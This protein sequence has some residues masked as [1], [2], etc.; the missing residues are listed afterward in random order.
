MRV[1]RLHV[2]VGRGSRALDRV[3]H[4]LL[5]VLANRLH[6]RVVQQRATA[7]HPLEQQ[8]RVALLPLLDLF[9]RTVGGVDNAA[10]PQRVVVVAIRPALDERWSLASPGPHH[11]LGHHLVHGHHVLPIDQHARHVVGHGPIRDILR[12]DHDFKT[13]GDGVLIIFAQEDD[14]QLPD[15]RQIHGLVE[16]ALVAGPIAKEGHGHPVIA[17]QLAAQRRPHRG[18]DGRPQD[19]RLPQDADTE[20]RQV[21]G[22]TLAF[23]QAGAFAKQLRH[24]LLYLPPLGNRMAV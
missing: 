22:A 12:R 6:P 17:L 18:G 24:G 21:H 23:T 5:N 15:R 3:L 11:G 14:G 10:E 9:L 1:Q 20:V 13:A 7:Q 2:R 4:H 8:D 19:A 16:G